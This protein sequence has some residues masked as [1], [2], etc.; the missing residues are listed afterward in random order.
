MGIFA[1][2]LVSLLYAFSAF[3]VYVREGDWKMAGVF[4]CYALANGLLI[5]IAYG[6][7][8]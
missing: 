2:F 8:H 6:K 7:Y 4:L 3:D 1:L 5:A